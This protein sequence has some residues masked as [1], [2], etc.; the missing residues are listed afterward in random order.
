LA[1]C[2]KQN[3]FIKGVQKTTSAKNK[4]IENLWI[5]IVCFTVWNGEIIKQ[6]A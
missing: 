3:I 6:Q 1:A 4:K 5:A 2:S